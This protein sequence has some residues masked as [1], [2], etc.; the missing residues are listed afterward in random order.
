MSSASC[1]AA[2]YV[3]GKAKTP[4]GRIDRQ[5]LVTMQIAMDLIAQGVL[6]MRAHKLAILQADDERQ[7]FST[8]AER[9]KEPAWK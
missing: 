4:N 5:R 3:A 2:G 8:A 1:G 6:P 7:G 9:R